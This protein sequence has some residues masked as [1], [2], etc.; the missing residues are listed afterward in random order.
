MKMAQPEWSIPATEQVKSKYFPQARVQE[1]VSELSFWV[2]HR[3]AYSMDNPPFAVSTFAGLKTHS[4]IE[5]PRMNNWVPTTAQLWHLYLVEGRDWYGYKEGTSSATNRSV[6]GR[7]SCGFSKARRVLENVDGYFETGEKIRGTVLQAAKL[8]LDLSELA[9]CV[10]TS[11]I[12]LEC[13]LASRLWCTN[14]CFLEFHSTGSLLVQATVTAALK[15][16]VSPV[17]SVAG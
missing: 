16:V 11:L 17:F 9:N 7:R 13:S 5:I 2:K 4:S 12:K 14:Q 6:V 10:P 8:S 3:L 1:T 15:L